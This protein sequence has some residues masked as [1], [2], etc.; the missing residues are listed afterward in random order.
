MQAA[1]DAVPS[2]EDRDVL[3]SAL[4]EKRGTAEAGYSGSYYGD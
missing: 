4:N 2:L 1:T 3:D